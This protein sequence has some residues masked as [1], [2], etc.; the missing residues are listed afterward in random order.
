M[1][2]KPSEKHRLGRFFAQDAS[3]FAIHA[4]KALYLV[5]AQGGIQS[6]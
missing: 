6:S 2:L 3:H 1:S 4:I 5:Q